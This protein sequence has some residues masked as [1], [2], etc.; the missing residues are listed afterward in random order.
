[1]YFG[2]KSKWFQVFQDKPHLS[3]LKDEEGSGACH[4][5]THPES[6]M[7]AAASSW[8]EGM[9]QPVDEESIWQSGMPMEDGS[10]KAL[11][12]TAGIESVLFS[13]GTVWHW[14]VVAATAVEVVG[15]DDGVRQSICCV[16]SC[17]VVCRRSVLSAQT[18][19]LSF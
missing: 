1:M 2:S 16:M 6:R 13:G 14:M 19:S 11:F 8:T 10:K 9:S 5:E 7:W 4:P 17:A 12:L 3:I 15:N 18:R